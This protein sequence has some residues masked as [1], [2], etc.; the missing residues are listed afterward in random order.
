MSRFFDLVSKPVRAMGDYPPARTAPAEAQAR[1]IK[2][3]SNEN[4][5]GPSQRA[6]DAM[7]RALS[8]S[9][10]YPDDDSSE[11]RRRLAAEHRL[12]PEQ[13]LVTAGSTGMLS[14][15]CYIMLGP[16]LNAVTSARS[17][18]LYSTAV[19]AAGAQLIEAPM[20][21]DGFDL[22]SILEAINEY[23]R[24]VLLANPN[25]PTG[26]VLTADSIDEFLRQVPGHI[27][28]VLDE[29]YH[30]Y[31]EHFAVTRKI[32]YS[33]SVEHVRRGA[34]VIVLRSFSKVHGLAGLRIG[35]GMGPSELLTYCAR[36]HDTYSV[37]MLAQAA[38]LAALD[39]QS[40]IAKTVSGNASEAQ[41]L[42]VGLSELGFRVV[43]TFAN[44]LYCD[45]GED[46]AQF[47]GRLRDEGVS[48]RALGMWGAPTS[49]RVSIGTPEQNQF[50]LNA[51][52]KVRETSATRTGREPR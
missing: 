41:I 30:E 52:R 14:L 49:I 46:A 2:L 29:A 48:I 20:R 36:L 33:R 3:D 7:R 1:L 12:S 51:V 11:L 23:T 39:D 5:Y 24:V 9:N 18:I 45:L 16:G 13:I 19:R 47:A 50:F 37:N 34:S 26:T 4:P 32:E 17:F 43:P 10:F 15:L 35:Y 42:G 27:V 28:V 25:N 6:V 21:D 44:F 38:A 22:A 8:N 40:H 31:A